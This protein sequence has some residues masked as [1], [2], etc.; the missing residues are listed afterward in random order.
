MYE[1]KVRTVE[2]KV[3]SQLEPYYR[4]EFEKWRI[5]Y[6]TE[7]QKVNT[8]IIQETSS[9]Q[10]EENVSISRPLNVVFKH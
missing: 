3:K 10:N 6:E 2:K 1:E 5:K 8:P 4:V 7:R 9:E